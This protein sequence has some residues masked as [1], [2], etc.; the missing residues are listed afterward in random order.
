MHEQRL[1]ADWPVTED[2]AVGGDTGNAQ[3]RSNVVAE[4]SGSG[5]ARRS[6]TTVNWAAVPKGR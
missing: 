1:T 6:G 3:S 2:G 4:F 5:T